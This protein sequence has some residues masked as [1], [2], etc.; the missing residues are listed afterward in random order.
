MSIAPWLPTVPAAAQTADPLQ[1]AVSDAAP[2]RVEISV[3]ARTL[4]TSP[5]DGLWSVATDWTDGWPSAWVHASP[6][7]VDREGEWTLVS[8]GLSLPGGVMA[9]STTRGWTIV[10]AQNQHLDVYGVVCTP[11]IWRMGEYLR[12]DD[13]KRL[14][15]VMD[16]SCGQ[17]TD[18]HGSTGEQIQQ[19]NFAQHGDMSSVFRLRGGFRHPRHVN[20]TAWRPAPANQGSRYRATVPAGTATRW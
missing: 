2:R 19:T 17:M 7:K 18:P 3:G 8:G 12:R 13:L 11:E 14:A 4:L 5:G 16:R 6:A 15:A 10:S 1:L 20:M 9:A